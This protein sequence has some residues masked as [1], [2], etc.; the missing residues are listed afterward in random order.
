MELHVTDAAQ[1]ASALARIEGQL[2]AVDLKVDSLGLQGATLVERVGNMKTTQDAHVLETQTRHDS[3]TKRV[4]SLE[5]TRTSWK[6][7]M[8]SVAAGVAFVVSVILIAAKEAFAAMA[9]GG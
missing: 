7:S 1:I 6:A 9:R 3:V 4:T 8:A 2:S 5:H